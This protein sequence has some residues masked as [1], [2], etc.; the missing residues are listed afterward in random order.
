MP[1][2]PKKQGEPEPACCQESEPGSEHSEQGSRLI[3]RV[4][5]PAVRFFVQ[6]QLDQVEALEFQLGGRD[7]QIL[8]GY[9]PTVAL[10]A[11]R[12]VYQGLHLSQ[13]QAEAQ[14]IYINLGQVLRGKPLR[15][16]QP[17]PVQGQVVMAAADLNA[18]LES[19][20]LRQAVQ[21]FLAQ[22]WAISHSPLRQQFPASTMPVDS[23]QASIQADRLQL[24]VTTGARVIWLKAGLAVRSGHVLVLTQPEIAI[25]SAGATEA[26]EDIEF[27]LGPEVA[28]DSLKLFPGRLEL[29]GT[30]N[31]LPGE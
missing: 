16:L 13:V 25:D 1:L 7:R 28:I 24:T 31:V 8:R 10:S 2:F 27:D 9:V 17:F 12:V 29:Y 19:S 3:G 6:T 21:D 26:L 23:A 18:S 4:L 5:P 30:V 20:L 22:L 11:A 15:L 14:E